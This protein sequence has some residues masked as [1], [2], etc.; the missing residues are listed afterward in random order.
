VREYSP[1][2]FNIDDCTKVDFSELVPYW[3]PEVFSEALFTDS[4]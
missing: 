3:V 1:K 4:Y 2:F